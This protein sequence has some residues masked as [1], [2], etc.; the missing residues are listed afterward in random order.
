M[1]IPSAFSSRMRASPDGFTV[2]VPSFVPFALARARPPFTRS[3]MMPRS[4]SANTPSIWNMALP[5]VVG[6]SRPCC[7]KVWYDDQRKVNRQIFDGDDTI[8]YAFMG[9]DPKAA[10]NR[11]LREAFG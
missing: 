3:R 2:R 9:Q 5:A 6:V 11:W 4:N 7:G 1:P 8:D 10:D